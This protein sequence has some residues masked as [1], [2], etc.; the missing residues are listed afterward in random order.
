MIEQ[1]KITSHQFKLLVVLFTIGSAILYIPATLAGD[2]KQDAWIAGLLG[3][4]FSIL[5]VILYNALAYRF[6]DMNFAEY[7]EIIL[8]K[9][10]GKFVT[11]IYSICFFFLAS[12]LL[13]DIGDFITIKILPETPIEAILTIFAVTLVL[14]TR[15]RLK[16][17]ALASEIVYPFA[18]FIILFLFIAVAPQIDFNNIFPIYENGYKPIVLAALPFITVPILQLSV[19]LMIFPYVENKNSTGK[20]FLIGAFTGGMILVV[21]TLIAIL[22]MGVALISNQY[23]PSYA[24]AQ[25]ISIGNFL[26]RIEVIMSEVWFF[27]IFFKLIISFYAAILAFSHVVNLK[28]YKPII[29]PAGMLLVE[30]SILIYPNS[31][32]TI[33]FASRDLLTLNATPGLFIPFLLLLVAVLRKKNYSIKKK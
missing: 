18:I 3:V 9:W 22:V 16:T 13:R 14:C 7:S 19:F 1:D 27:T 32:Y 2:A 25:R 28:D 4:L 10:L 26:E 12:Y 5:L 11:T 21:F 15:L 8:G 17:M 30:L 23:F 20:A 29:L 33:H 24:L 6:P 31:S